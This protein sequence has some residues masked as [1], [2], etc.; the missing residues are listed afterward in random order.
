MNPVLYV[1]L[2]GSLNMSAG[3]AAAQAVHAAMMLSPD[4]LLPFNGQDK[5][6]K[7]TVIIL[8]ARDQDQ[9]HGI[10]DYL[11][12]ANINHEYYVDEGVNEV[13]AFSLTALAVAPIDHDD[14]EKREIFAALPTYPTYRGESDKE[15]K[16]YDG[17]QD[18]CVEH[19]IKKRWY[20]TN[21]HYIRRCDGEY[22]VRS[23]Y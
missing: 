17:P 18:T 16:T 14:Y 7:R 23:R 12:E 21:K 4:D 19:E 6:Y 22:S 13:D 1:I 20:E 10:S 5:P 2:N 8:E 3:K 9:L 11:F 15:V